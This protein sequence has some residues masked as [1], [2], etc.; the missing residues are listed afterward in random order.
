[1][2]DNVILQI[3][4]IK[5]YS[6]NRKLGGRSIVSGTEKYFYHFCRLEKKGLNEDRKKGSQ[7]ENIKYCTLNTNN[8]IITV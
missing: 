1:M 5:I 2:V 6:S 8:T 4:S 3:N 7:Q